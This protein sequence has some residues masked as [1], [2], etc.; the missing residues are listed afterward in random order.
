M[1]KIVDKLT[2]FKI[3][4]KRFDILKEVHYRVLKNFETQSLGELARYYTQLVTCDHMWTYEE[5][6]ATEREL[7]FE[8]MEQFAPKIFEKAHFEAL[9]LGNV[10][11]EDAIKMVGSIEETF[12]TRLNSRPLPLSLVRRQ[13]EHDLSDGANLV[14]K[15]INSIH[16]TKAIQIYYQIGPQTTA[17]NV[18]AELLVHLLSEP[19][20]HVLRTQEQLGY[21]AFC[22]LR[23]AFGVQG[24]RVFIQSDHEPDFLDA[25]IEAFI[26]YAAKLLEEMPDDEFNT[27]KSGLIAKRLEKPKQLL[28]YARKIF[29][30]I[31]SKQYHFERDDVE[32]A[33]MS[34]LTKAD[35]VNFFQTFIAKNGA[36]R[37]KL[38]VRIYSKNG[39]TTSESIKDVVNDTAVSENGISET[40]VIASN[41]QTKLV[42]ISDVIEFKTGLGLYPLIRPHVDISTPK[43]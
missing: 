22:A 31:S 35:V 26:E 17:S 7:T 28:T 32:V 39:S 37:K 18:T 42:E 16:Q 9:V 33:A 24:I 4:R 5:R 36:R 34:S 38:S 25:R 43:L 10:T 13:R 12:R 2:N 3:D 29:E 27:H 30:E 1:N 19:C 20:F 40:E 23:R 6:I 41:V 15:N 8:L 14:Y 11:K 21:V